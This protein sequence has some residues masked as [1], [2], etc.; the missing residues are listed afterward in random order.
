MAKV[1]ETGDKI[2]Y[3]L[4]NELQR[5]ADAYD[6]LQ[7]AAKENGETKD[8]EKE[9]QEAGKDLEKMKVDELKELAAESG[10]NAK[11]MR[12]DEL[13]EAIKGLPDNGKGG[14]DE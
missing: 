9:G 5:K 3:K 12:K 6:A 2:P 4:L 11:G 14:E 8:Q 13:I 10:V 7:A 1:W